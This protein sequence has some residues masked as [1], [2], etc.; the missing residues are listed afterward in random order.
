MIITV[1]SLLFVGVVRPATGLKAG[2]EDRLVPAHARVSIDLDQKE[3]FLGENVLLH[4]CIENTGKEPFQINLGDDQGASRHLRFKVTALDAAG[5]PCDDPDPSGLDM[6]GESY[7]PR[8]EPGQKRYESIPLLHYRRIEKSG[9]YKIQVSHDLGWSQTPNRKLPVAETTVTFIKPNEDEARKLVKAMLQ[10]PPNNGRSSDST[11][12]SEPYPDFSVLRDPVYLPILLEHVREKSEQALAGI[13]SIATPRATEALIQLAGHEDA[14]FALSAAQTLNMRL[15]DPQLDNELPARNSL[16]NDYLAVRRWLVTRSWRARLTDDVAD[17]ARKFLAR[18][19]RQSLECGGYMLQCAGRRKD[20][21][22][23]IRALDR[24]IAAAATRPLEQNQYPRPRGACRELLRAARVLSA[25]ALQEP[26][27]IDTAG[28][29]V[30]FLCA[31]GTTGTFRPEGWEHH[32][33]RLLQHEAAFVREVALDNLP[34]PAP[35]SLLKLL[36]RLIADKDV[37]VQ[38]AACHVAEKTKRPE[39][40]EPVLKALATAREHWQFNAASTAAL[41]LGAK[42]ER[43]EILV[44]RLD[45]EGVTKHCLNNLLDTV[46]E[47]VGGYS[48]P[49]DKWTAEEAKACK[50]RWLRFLQAH[51]MQLK[52]G[53]RFKR[54][55]PAITPDLFPTMK[56]GL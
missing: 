11:A 18:E 52:A 39:C 30:V 26:P 42:W 24:E 17:L 46:V 48:G 1:G 2:E 38:I 53:Q 55:D 5:K 23:L 44:A 43:L 15:P 3:Y 34:L 40:K 28:Q 54:D 50:E 56:L 14:H 16:L 9:V 37:D 41:A 20:L 21:P 47:N 45:E 25:R 29:A 19:D 32:Y 27:R 36:P 6:G 22:Y 8:V 12:K 33:A 13:G 49:S 35:E 51:G 4:F 10:A 7:S 31:I